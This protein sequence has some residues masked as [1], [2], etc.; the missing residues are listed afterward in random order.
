MKKPLLKFCG[1]MRAED[2]EYAIQLG[3]DAIG[4]IMVPGSKRFVSFEQVQA[5]KQRIPAHIKLVCVV[6]NLPKQEISRILDIIQP[7]FIQFHG[8][9]DTEFC[10]SF[11]YPYIKAVTVNTQEDVNQA[12]NHYTHAQALLFDAKGGEGIAFDWSL[13]PRT[14]LPEDGRLYGLAGGINRLNIIQSLALKPDI[15]DLS[16]GIESLQNPVKGHKSQ[17]EMKYIFE[18]VKSSL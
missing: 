18:A 9:E 16:S 10:H 7:G 12:I 3:V 11:A 15:I 8:E 6:R 4:V 14:K 1:M 2:I 5:L 13:F 17:D